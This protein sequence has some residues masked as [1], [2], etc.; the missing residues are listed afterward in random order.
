MWRRG[1][2]MQ[3]TH[4]TC[5]CALPNHTHHLITHRHTCSRSATLIFSLGTLS[6][7]SDPRLCSPCRGNLMSTNDAFW[8]ATRRPS[9]G[10]AGALSLIRP[11]LVPGCFLLC[12]YDD[13]AI[14][15]CLARAA[16]LP[17]PLGFER[18]LDSHATPMRHYAI[19]PVPCSADDCRYDNPDGIAIVS[20]ALIHDS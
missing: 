5:A 9:P 10:A 20:H 6:T 15:C 13:L 8:R 2:R 4:A 1:W 19:R 12:G 11:V 16:A 17:L 14:P 3:G 7:C 18:Q